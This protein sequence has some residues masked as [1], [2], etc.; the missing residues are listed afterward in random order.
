MGEIIRFPRKEPAGGKNPLE[1]EGAKAAKVFSEMLDYLANLQKNNPASRNE[2]NIRLRR[3]G[4]KEIPT[5]ELWAMITKSTE[6]QWKQH[7]SQYRALAEEWLER[8]PPRKNE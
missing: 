5:S 2:E 4:L 6:L 1:T 7:P 3:H 8:F